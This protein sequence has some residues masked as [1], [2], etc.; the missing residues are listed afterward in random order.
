MPEPSSSPSKTPLPLLG[1]K[2]PSNNHHSMLPLL[3]VYIAEY[4]IN[5]GVAPTLLF[6]LPSTPFTHYRSFYPT[7]GAIYQLGVFLSRSSTTFFRVHSLYIPSYLQI[8]NLVL[9]T[10]HAIFDFLPNVYFVMIIIFWEGLLGGLV[11]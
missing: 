5:Q 10:L 2:T 4:T 6:P 9:L 11:D 3:L 7:Y 8:A 1:V